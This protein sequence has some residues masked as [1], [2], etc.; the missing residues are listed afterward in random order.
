MKP[1][2][3]K[4]HPM[5]EPLSGGWVYS[6]FRFCCLFLNNSN[7]AEG[8]NYC[9]CFVSDTSLVHGKAWTATWHSSFK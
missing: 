8:S 3:L 5:L 6:H 7:M 9:T 1:L 2:K 4:L